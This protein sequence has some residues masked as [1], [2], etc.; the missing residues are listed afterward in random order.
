M[1]LEH[2]W[3]RRK[4]VNLDAFVYHRLAGLIRANILNVGL[5]GAF[6]DTGHHTLPPQ[7]SLEL[8]FALHDSD[9]RTLHQMEAL[10]IHHN[11]TGYGLMFKNFRPSAFQAIKEA[12]YAA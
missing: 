5:E 6:I 11:R 9:M 3:S 1:A 8:T 10:V 7:A 12:L 4:Q 2:R